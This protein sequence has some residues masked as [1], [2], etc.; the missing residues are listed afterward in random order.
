MAI[1]KHVMTAKRKAALR[2]AQIAS[3]LKRRRKGKS[4]TKTKR[5]TR[6]NWSDNV[7]GKNGGKPTLADIR[8]AGNSQYY[9]G[10]R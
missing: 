6:K 5:K 3:A 4:K 2:K 10:K 9:K 1:R 7:K 8:R